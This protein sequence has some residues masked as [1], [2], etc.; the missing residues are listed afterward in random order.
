MSHDLLPFIR[1]W[2]QIFQ[3]VKVEQP[4]SRRHACPHFITCAHVIYTH[5]ISYLA[6]VLQVKATYGSLH[7]L[8]IPAHVACSQF[9]CT[10]FQLGTSTAHCASLLSSSIAVNNVGTNIRLST[11]EYTAANYEYVMHTN[12]TSAFQ[13]TQVTPRLSHAHTSPACMRSMCP[14]AL[15]KAGQA[16]RMHVPDTHDRPPHSWCTRC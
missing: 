3:A 10:V 4:S 7:I 8:G 15:P 2:W 9:T 1:A 13:L 16:Q 14:P 5:N 6:D 12:L 11:L